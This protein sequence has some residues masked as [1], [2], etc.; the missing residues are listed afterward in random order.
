MNFD[1]DKLFDIVSGDDEDFAEVRDKPVGEWRHGTEH[2]KI[3][4]QKS[5]GKFIRIK[6]RTTPDGFESICSHEEVAPAQKTIT[7]YRAVKQ[8]QTT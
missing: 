1:E 6:Y 2:E 7:V 4:K 3:A 5:T 8:E